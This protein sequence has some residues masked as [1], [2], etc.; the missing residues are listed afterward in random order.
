MAATGNKLAYAGSATVACTLTSLASG[1]TRESNVRSNSTNLNFDDHVAV[2]FTIASGTPGAGY[3]VNVYA[4]GSVDGTLWPIVM[5][6]TGAAIATG[7]GDA[8]F[9]AIGVPQN[10]KLVGSYGISTATS[11]AERTFRTPPFS[12]AAA[13]GGALPAAYSIMVENQTGVALSS[14]TTSTAQLV[15]VNGIYTTS[16]N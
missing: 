1:S 9:G 8:S 7:A 12:V 5:N 6:G 16:G 15:E 4:N 3:A 14:S 10:V 13:F 11:S 2:T